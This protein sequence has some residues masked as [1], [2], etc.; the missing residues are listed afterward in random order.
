MLGRDCPY[1]GLETV[2][3]ALVVNHGRSELVLPESKEALA[4]SSYCSRYLPSP[5]ICFRVLHHGPCSLEERAKYACCL[6]GSLPGGS[7]GGMYP[8]RPLFCMFYPPAARA[9]NLLAGS[10]YCSENREIVTV[11]GDESGIVVS[12]DASQP[13]WRLVA[14][15]LATLRVVLRGY[16]AELAG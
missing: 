7:G 8:L 15:V 3:W 12:T 13:H 10:Q 6:V 2:A 9:E 1:S 5:D 11:A 16:G 4:E 14:Q